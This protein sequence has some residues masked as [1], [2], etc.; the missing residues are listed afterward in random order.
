MT[1]ALAALHD[2]T[3]GGV[4]YSANIDF[5]NS[6]FNPTWTKYATTG[7][8]NNLIKVMQCD[9][10]DPYT[11]IYVQLDN[12]D[13]YH[14]N[15]TSWTKIMDAA[16]A[17]TL[18][19]GADE[20]GYIAIDKS[21]TGTIYLPCQKAVSW[22]KLLK[23][24]DYG[25]TWSVITVVNALITG[26]PFIQAYG[27]N[28]IALTS[29]P[30]SRAYFSTNG[31][32]SWTLGI[33]GRASVP[34]KQDVHNPT[35]YYCN[36]GSSD[37]DLTVYTV[38][39]ATQLQV[40]LNLGSAYHVSH[41]CSHWFNRTVAGHQRILLQSAGGLYLY[42]TTDYW[43]TVDSPPKWTDYSGFLFNMYDLAAA[44]ENT[45]YMLIGGGV[46][47]S[48]GISRVYAK[49]GEGAGVPWVVSGANYASAPYTDS[50]PTPSGSFI[51]YDGL[52][53][54]DAPASSGVYVYAD[55]MG[56][57]ASM[58]TY[59][60][61]GIPMFGDRS[62]FRDMP[63]DGFDIYHAQDVRAVTPQIHAPW[64]DASPPPAGYGIVSDG[65]K[66]IV[67]TDELAL[68]SDLHNPVTLAVDADTLLGLNVQ[69]LT[70]DSQSANRVFA[71][72]TT[73]AAADPT[74]RAIVAADLGT[75]TA[76]ATTY[77]RGD[78]SWQ[79]IDIASTVLAYI[80]EHAIDEDLSGLCDG[81]RTV[82]ILANEYKI[83]T[84]AVYLNGVRQLIVTDYT[85]DVG[86]DQITMTTA[87]EAGDIL[88]I[89]Y[90]LADAIP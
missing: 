41:G 30:Y 17:T 53:V 60:G 27:T 75:G 64:D 37:F 29:A 32:A 88:I 42:T 34:H 84:T 73:G 86:Y 23:S 74:F 3:Y 15:G 4:Y 26:I 25:A 12:D 36:A 66:W 89:D 22:M 31:G 6:G 11:H 48:P 8:A 71:G 55:E 9:A 24:T 52:W 69:Q 18:T 43:S 85:E 77:L 57:I 49:N 46:S 7:L 62:S 47:G 83:E 90:V 82:F 70:L 61:L 78:L 35:R 51:A 58:P 63:A 28:L 68:E 65:A 5:T 72:P 38:S 21:T 76:D 2:T 87:P 40:G 44:L 10:F 79:T 67:S 14:W 50:I 56:D 39:T 13:V 16:T 20:W 33:A 59:T 19:G 54:G 81:A 45:D 1:K 80:H